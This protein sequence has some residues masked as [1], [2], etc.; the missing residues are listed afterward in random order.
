LPLHALESAAMG[1]VAYALLTGRPPFDGTN[2]MDVMIAHIRD[3]LVWP[4]QLE[5]DVPADLECVILRCLAKSP[6]DR[7]Q[8]VDG[9]DQALAECAA[10][11]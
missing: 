2:A 10:A 8:D 5:A 11:N 9:L 7:F 3:E 4:S 1:A 6:E